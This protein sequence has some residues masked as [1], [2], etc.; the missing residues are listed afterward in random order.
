[1]WGVGVEGAVNHD[2]FIRLHPERNGLQFTTRE[3]ERYIVYWKPSCL[4]I[5]L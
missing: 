1:M 4:S 5:Y 2:Q 3:G